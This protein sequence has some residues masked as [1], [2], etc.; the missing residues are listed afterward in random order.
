MALGRPSRIWTAVWSLLTIAA[1][2]V[3]AAAYFVEV[4]L[5]GERIA[6]GI[7]LTLATTAL[8]WRTGGRPLI[9]LVLVPIGAAAVIV[10][11]RGFLYA[12]AT[13]A[14]AIVVAVLALMVTQP[15]ATFVRTVREVFV[16]IG[17]A[18]V[19]GLAVTGWHADLNHDRYDY[20]VLGGAIL[21]AGVLVYRLGAGFHGLGRR[22]Y[23]VAGAALLLITL[24]L[25][26]TEALNRW[27]PTGAIEQFQDFRFWIRDL[28]GA[29]PHPIEALLGIPAIAYG[30]F[31]RARRRQGW[32]VVAFGAAATAPSTERFMEHGMSLQGTVLGAVYTLVVGLLIGLV[33]IRGEQAFTGS[34]GTRSRRAEEAEAV[35]P[36]PSRT[37][38]LS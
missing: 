16:A 8:A 28:I 6:A 34:K 21:M 17:V 12:G 36:E 4:P 15:A 37:Y 29:V 3:L 20:L 1:L 33:V 14:T 25:A 9:P 35:R 23:L 27:G 7:T 19:G 10:A 38:P 13:V 11:D 22:G 31:V 18:T 30:T 26:Y 24:A 5:W 2:G 32:W